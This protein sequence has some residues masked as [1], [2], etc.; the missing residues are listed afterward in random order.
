MLVGSWTIN[1]F[2]VVGESSKIS[3]NPNT[4]DAQPR[5]TRKGHEGPGEFGSVDLDFVYRNG[6][7]NNNGARATQKM[8]N[9]EKK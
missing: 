3:F 4:G 8:S 9:R 7:T 6:E 5:H 1:P 2:V